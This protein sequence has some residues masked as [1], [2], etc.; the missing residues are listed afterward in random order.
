MNSQT[1][2]TIGWYLV[3]ASTGGL[4]G[5][6]I[7]HYILN[8][9]DENAEE[10]KAIGERLEEYGSEGT[11]YELRGRIVTRE[12]YDAYMAA[13]K[14]QGTETPDANLTEQEKVVKPA[15][16]DYTQFSRVKESIDAV[17]QKFLGENPVAPEPSR[18]VVETEPHIISLEEYADTSNGYQ[19]SMTTYYQENFTL[20]DEEEDVI[21]SAEGILGHGW[22]LNFG[23]LSG[24]PDTVYI[25]NDHLRA[26][27]EVVRVARKYANKA[28]EVKPARPA[29]PHRN[30]RAKP[31]D[32]TEGE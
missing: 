8:H 23:Q 27:F 3:G 20:V 17:A 28:V 16:T 7:A 18:E 6:L 31:D 4:I 26:D 13:V 19:K 24:D 32:N 5:S 1:I 11:S 29:R 10:E 12:E 30:R 22:L 9:Q 2:R 21:D 14:E 25:R 15:V